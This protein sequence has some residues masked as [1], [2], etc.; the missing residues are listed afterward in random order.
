MKLTTEQLKKM[1]KEELESIMAED[2]DAALEPL[3]DSVLNLAKIM[4]SKNLE[5][6]SDFDLS[7]PLDAAM[8]MNST[9]RSLAKAK[10]IDAAAMKEIQP[11]YKAML[12]AKKAYDKASRG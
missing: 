1:I 11:A 2:V 3:Q 10:K 8:T 6:P 7:A 9:L 4:K 12:A 5:V